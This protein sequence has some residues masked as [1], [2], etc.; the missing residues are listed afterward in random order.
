MFSI[1]KREKKLPVKD[2]VWFSKKMK[3]I[4]LCKQIG[5]VGANELCIVMSSFENSLQSIENEAHQ[6]NLRVNR[7]SSLSYSEKGAVANLFDALKLKNVGISPNSFGGVQVKVILL[8]RYPIYNKDKMLHEQIIKLI[9]N[10]TI[11]VHSAFDEPLLTQ[12]SSGRMVEMLQKLGLKE[13]EVMEHSLISSSI[14]NA[15]KKIE[16]KVTYEKT[17]D[18][19]SDW[20]YRNMRE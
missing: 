13:D 4:G 18:S 2:F 3:L 12:F 6:N 16:E 8:E 14:Q 20:F 1:F 19:E 10:A 7:L 11:E 5:G 17:S 9:P 15:M